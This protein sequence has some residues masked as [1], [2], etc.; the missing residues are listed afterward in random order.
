MNIPIVAGDPA[1]TRA[2]P[3]VQVDPA[4]L[5]VGGTE[6]ET[7]AASQTDQALGATGAAGDFLSHL[8][9]VVA[10]AATAAVSIKDGAGSAIAVFP[11]SPG[12]GVGTYYVPIGARSSAGAWSVTTGAGVSVV[13]VGN[14]T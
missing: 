7:V 14:F 11:N 5:P 1:A 2:T 9:V 13:A 8:L 10:T 6:Y 4:G 3:V 12:G